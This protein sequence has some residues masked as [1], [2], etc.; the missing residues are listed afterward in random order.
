M[1]G[2]V[3]IKAPVAG[4]SVGL[5]MDTTNPKNY[6]LLTD[7]QGP[8]DHFG[9]MD[10]KV[11]GTK[12]GITAIQLDIKVG[13]IPADVLK[14]ALQ[15]AKKGRLHILEAILAEIP[16]PRADIS[17]NAPKIIS[18]KIDPTQIGMVIGSGGKTV[19]AIR[20]KSGAEITIEDDGT[21][22]ATG[23]NGAAEK[24][25]EMIR[26]MTREWKVGDEAEGTVIKII[27]VGAIV[28]LSE[29]AEGM[30]HV[31]EIA[32]FRVEKV[33]DV[34]A[35]GQVVPVKVLAVDRE[36]GRISLSIKARQAD[37]IKNPKA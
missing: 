21:V 16:A 5:M 34:L 19:N 8:E 30:V 10:F 1:D 26:G 2:G 20:E 27:E 22:F 25:I 29:F 4:V 11:A 9:D 18:T 12:D 35:V 28:A 3:P 7:I 36:R 13:G 14:D 17:P 24:A 37:F 31:S 33:A 23:K 6:K 15:S 32:A